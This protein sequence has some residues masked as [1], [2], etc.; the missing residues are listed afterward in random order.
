MATNTLRPIK[1]GSPQSNVLGLG[2]PSD[3]KTKSLLLENSWLALTIVKFTVLL[4]PVC[5]EI[6]VAD[7]FTGEDGQ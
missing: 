3:G 6:F 2:P 4:L 1:N 5:E 7:K